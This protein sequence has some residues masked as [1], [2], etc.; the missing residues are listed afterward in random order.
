MESRS[1]AG[2]GGTLGGGWEGGGCLDPSQVSHVG[3]K[4]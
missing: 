1:E 2:L 3:C 4:G